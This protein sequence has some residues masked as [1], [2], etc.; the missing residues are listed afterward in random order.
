M[1]RRDAL[2]APSTL[3]SW[4]STPPMAWL[5]I[6]PPTW[7]QR[8]VS[9]FR[10][11][12][13]TEAARFVL[14]LPRPFVAQA[15]PWLVA[16]VVVT[17]SEP[18]PPHHHIRSQEYSTQPQQRQAQRPEKPE[19]QCA[20]W[21]VTRTWF[22]E[23][24]AEDCTP[25]SASADGRTAVLGPV[26]QGR[27]EEGTAEHGPDLRADRFGMELNAEDRSLA[28]ADGHDRRGFEFFAG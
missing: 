9:S 22:E 24:S 4:S 8:R 13:S 6:A 11:R 7:V 28:M 2:G 26:L 17:P 15:H 14:G 18:M 21:L 25:K 23:V 20:R 10:S 16:R 27:F 5:V 1:L 3:A 19:K 12:R